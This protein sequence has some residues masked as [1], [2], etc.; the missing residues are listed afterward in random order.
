MLLWAL[1][2]VLY[3]LGLSAPV[4]II[5]NPNPASLVSLD[6]N[7]HK[8]TTALDQVLAQCPSLVGDRAWYTPTSWLA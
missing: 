1:R 8:T 6:A 2:R 4:K 3:A 7:G 5:R